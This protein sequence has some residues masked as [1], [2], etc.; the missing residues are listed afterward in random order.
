MVGVSV[1]LKLRDS[2]R[3]R[4]VLW[5]CSST[6]CS[7]VLGSFGPSGGCQDRGRWQG[8]TCRHEVATAAG[9]SACSDMHVR[10]MLSPCWLH[11]ASCYISYIHVRVCVMSHHV[12]KGRG[13]RFCQVIQRCHPSCPCSSDFLCPWIEGDRCQDTVVSIYTH[14]HTHTHTHSGNSWH[15]ALGH[16][17]L[18]STEDQY[19]GLQHYKLTWSHLHHR[20]T[21]KPNLYACFFKRCVYLEITAVFIRQIQRVVHGITL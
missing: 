19:H 11:T 8:A 10:C 16:L 12:H 5:L 2:L 3:M 4:A 13:L 17:L 7:L 20:I 14:T 9:L 21:P 6:S 1:L 18:M 15:L